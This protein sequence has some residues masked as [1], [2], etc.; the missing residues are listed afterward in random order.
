MLVTGYNLMEPELS[1][2]SPLTNIEILLPQIFNTRSALLT[3]PS[4]RFLYYNP[5]TFPELPQ[6]LIEERNAD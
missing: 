2:Q 4:I 3:D 1:R 5:E 6:R